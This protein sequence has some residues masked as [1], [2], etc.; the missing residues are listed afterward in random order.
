MILDIA[1]TGWLNLRRDKAGLILSFLVPIVFF[2]I[3]ASIFGGRRQTTPTVRLA[4]ADEDRSPESKR[5]IEALDAESSIEIRRGPDRKR[6]E[7]VFDAKSAEAFVRSG[8]IS[9]ALIIPKGFGATPISFAGANAQAPTFRIISD[10]SDPIAANVVSGMLQKTVMTASPASMIRGGMTAMDQYGGGLTPQQR[11][12]MEQNIQTVEQGG[13]AQSMSGGLVNVEVLD[14][15]GQSKKSPMVA[16]YAAGVGVMFLLFTA[17]GAGGSLL[18]ENE[19]GTLDRILSTRVTM[20]RLLLGKLLYQWSLAVLQLI[21]MFL[22]GALVF[23]LELFSHLGGFAVMTAA[24]A[25][26][27]S[28]FGLFMASLSHTRQQLGAISTLIVLSISAVGGSMFPRFLMPEA[29]QKAGLVLFNAW[30]IEGYTRVF[31]REE[32]ISAV[33]V[34]ALVLIGWGVV[35]FLLARRFARRWEMA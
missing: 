35:F 16:F 29:M 20:T 12:L 18:E 10:S 17:T 33:V 9:A 8:S 5:L 31:W 6:P 2:S 19:S 26:A 25:L 3:F 11:R 7:V 23:G 21:V 34:P 4:V 30:A 13:A 22:W 1:R 32:P 24:T 27:C 15:L 28:A 14:V